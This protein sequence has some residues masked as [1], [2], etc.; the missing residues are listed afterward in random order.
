M[1][2]TAIFNEAGGLMSPIASSLLV[3]AVQLIASLLNMIFIDRVGRKMLLIISCVGGVFGMSIF[4]MHQFFKN[5]LPNTEWIPVC[6][7][8]I[9]IYFLGF[10]IWTVPAVL[11][12]DIAPLKVCCSLNEC[13]II[14]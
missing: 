11:A 12:I 3:A 10:G 1:N 5:Q 7:V 8:I 4:S 6:C 14:T 2:S 13:S 9:I